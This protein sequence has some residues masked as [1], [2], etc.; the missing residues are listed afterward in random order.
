MATRSI[1]TVAYAGVA[2]N[3]LRGQGASYDKEGQNAAMARYLAATPHLSIREA[4][5]VLK[6]Y[7]IHGPLRP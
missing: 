6:R 1:P 5:T 7:P 3:S 2:Y 4:F